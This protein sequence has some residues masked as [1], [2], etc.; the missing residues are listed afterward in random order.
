[1][2]YLSSSP[3]SSPPT[4]DDYRKN[5]PFG[6]SKFERE[7]AE[8]K[9]TEEFSNAHGWSCPCGVGLETTGTWNALDAK[10]CRFCGQARRSL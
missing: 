1:M 8:E 7:L 2:K 5:Y 9:K 4:S 3:F 6:P 10:I